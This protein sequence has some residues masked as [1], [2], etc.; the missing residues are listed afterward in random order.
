MRGSTS[1]DRIPVDKLRAEVDAAGIDAY[2]L[3]AELGW[4]DKRGWIDAERVKRILGQHTYQAGRRAPETARAST[5][6]PPNASARSSAR[7]PPLLGHNP[8]RTQPQRA[9]RGSRRDRGAT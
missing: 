3:A 7:T 9:K 1:R 5:T 8:D 2:E 6:R 4:R